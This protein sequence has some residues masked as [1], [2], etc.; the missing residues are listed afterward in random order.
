MADKKPAFTR[1]PHC[2]QRYGSETSLQAHVNDH[3]VE[4]IKASIHPDH[5][6]V[7]NP[8]AHHDELRKLLKRG[9]HG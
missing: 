5:R 7:L 1:C 8:A 4:H 3:K 6:A 2:T 9:G